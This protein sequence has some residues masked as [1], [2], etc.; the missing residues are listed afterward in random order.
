[1]VAFR[2]HFDGRVI[3]PEGHISLPRD[4]ELVFQVESRPRL[5]SGRALLRHAGTLDEQTASEMLAAIKDCE[6]IGD[7]W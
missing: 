3:I 6:R 1:M 7:E 2:G 5:A 4:R